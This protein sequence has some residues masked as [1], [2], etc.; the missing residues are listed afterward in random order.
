M[1]AF[2]AACERCAGDYPA[3]DLKLQASEAA[4]WRG[5]SAAAVE[6]H[7]DLNSRESQ[8]M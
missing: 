1:S 8:H 7:E 4:S 3:E 2:A 5:G 6:L